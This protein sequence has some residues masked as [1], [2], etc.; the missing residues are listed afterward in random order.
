MALGPAGDDLLVMGAASGGMSGC[1][2]TRYRF[3]GDALRRL[4]SYFH[5]GAVEFSRP[6]RMGDRLLVFFCG[7][8]N[9]CEDGVFGL[10]SGWP[11]EYLFVAGIIDVGRLAEPKDWQADWYSTQY[12]PAVRDLA[13]DVEAERELGPLGQAFEEKYAQ[14]IEGMLVA[15]LEQ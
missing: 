6:Y 10:P 4:G 7:R 11:D 1:V 2:L 9:P 15:G 13:V 8:R 12:L 14:D 3:E 5:H